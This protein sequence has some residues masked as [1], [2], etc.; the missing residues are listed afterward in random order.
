M[1]CLTPTGCFPRFLSR[2]GS[3]EPSSHA[4][5]R[6]QSHEQ[7]IRSTSGAES[8][9]TKKISRLVL[10]VCLLH[11]DQSFSLQSLP[12]KQRQRR[13]AE[14]CEPA[15]PAV[16][17]PEG[18]RE[19]PQPQ[20]EDDIL[21]RLLS[22]SDPSTAGWSTESSDQAGHDTSS[23]SGPLVDMNFSVHT[24]PGSQH[25]GV[26]TANSGGDT[27]SRSS[28]VSWHSSLH[29][30]VQ[31]GRAKIVELLLKHHAD[32]DQRDSEGL[33][34][35]MHAAMKGFD[36]IAEL[37][38]ASGAS[39]ECVNDQDQSVVHLAVLYWRER[40]LKRVLQ[41]CKGDGAIV[42]RYTR[43]GKT[44]L[45]IAIEMGFEVAVQLLLEFGADVHARH[46][47]RRNGGPRFSEEVNI[48]EYLTRIPS[49]GR[50]TTPNKTTLSFLRIQP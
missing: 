31:S 23:F 35:L 28:S 50:L 47:A 7:G 27:S 12:E 37:L 22:V 44:P 4:G 29:I 6:Q 15:S 46:E 26:A 43:D 40:L 49:G 20:L 2:S 39:V 45:H 19:P 17:T 13:D 38:L 10:L 5:A 24:M 1:I 34:A 21:T 3:G 36:E 30:A 16:T 9:S 41:H 11:R 42:N 25:D 33:T 8:V 14:P 32:C 48:K 18:G